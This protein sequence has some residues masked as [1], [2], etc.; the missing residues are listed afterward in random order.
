[1][2]IYPVDMHSLSSAHIL[3]VYSLVIML[4]NNSLTNTVNLF[5]SWLLPG[6]VGILIAFWGGTFAVL[7]ILV[8]LYETRKGT[9]LD[10]IAEEIEEDLEMAH[11]KQT[12]PQQ[13]LPSTK[14]T[15]RHSRHPAAI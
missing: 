7:V 6:N 8:I 1:M 15:T 2:Q 12:Q 11:H 9:V 4:L 5:F 3:L 10:I 13:L 14:H